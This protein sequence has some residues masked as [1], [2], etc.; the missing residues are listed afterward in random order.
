MAGA[1]A[2]SLAL[3][4]ALSART[5]KG[6]AGAPAADQAAVAAYFLNS[7]KGEKGVFDGGAVLKKEEVEAARKSVWDSWRQA[8]SDFEELRLPKMSELGPQGCLGYW[9][10]PEMLEPHAIFYYLWGSCG[11]RPEAGY[12]AYIYLHGSGAPDN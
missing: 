8:N 12:P 1:L 10:I 6:K 4:C 2:L 3:S 7:L 9:T 5:P 11:E